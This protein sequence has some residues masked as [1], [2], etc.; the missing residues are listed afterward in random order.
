VSNSRLMTFIE[1]NERHR[2]PRPALWSLYTAVLCLAFLA[3]LVDAALFG[4]WPEIVLATAWGLV[5][6]CGVWRWRRDLRRQSDQNSC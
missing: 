2:P 5:I 4:H 3:A 6:P 1:E